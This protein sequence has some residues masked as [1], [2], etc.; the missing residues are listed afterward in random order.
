MITKL[1]YG[2]TNTY[3]IRGK[4]ANI[5]VDTDYAGTLPAFYKTI[6]ENNVK[7]TE[8]NYIL[9]THFHPD[10]IGIVSELME[11]GVT[12]LLMES[13]TEYVHYSDEIFGRETY[14]NYKPIDERA[15]HLLTFAESR[16]FLTDAGISGEIISTPSH[17]NDS[18]SVVLD[19]GICIVGDLEPFEYLGAYEE[20]EALKQ[21]WD[22]ILSYNP[23]RV[24]YAHA[25]SKEIYNKI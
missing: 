4:T 22:N 10:H 17:S 15:A 2:N 7:V 24:L 23:K 19:E 1:K 16:K 3:F 14:I 18:I 8:I 6:K 25:N 11:Q 13:Q 9:A 12:L 21:D 5:L 20:N